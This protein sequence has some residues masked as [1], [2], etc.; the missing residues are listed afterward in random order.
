ML[1]RENPELLSVKDSLVENQNQLEKTMATVDSQLDKALQNLK[2]TKAIFNDLNQEYAGRIEEVIS[3]V[4]TILENM[5]VSKSEI[6]AVEKIFDGT[7]SD[8]NNKLDEVS[9]QLDDL[10]A[11]KIPPPPVE[12]LVKA[13]TTQI[14]RRV[15]DVIKADT[16]LPI[17]RASRF[18][19]IASSNQENNFGMLNESTT[20][21]VDEDEVI[22]RL[23][24]QL[25][26]SKLVQTELSAD[27]IELK[28]DLRKAYKEIVS[29]QTN[30]KESRLIIEELETAKNSLYKTVD[31][32][33]ATAAA[34]SKRVKKLEADLDQARDD[35]RQSRQS[36]LLEQ[37]RSNS[38]ISSIT[39]EL[40]RTRKELDYARV[41]ARQNAGSAQ[42]LAFFR[43]RI[44]KS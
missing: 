16:A 7:I 24:S 33:P 6:L 19:G 26:S 13:P 34:V 18:S 40:E 39:S 43:K 14:G 11:K 20:G 22:D 44:S 23:R 37:Q 36:L 35:L 25:E 38:M 4:L 42:R 9:L 31:G 15:A 5:R 30:L 29:L 41:S 10:L 8:Y 32:G 12:K 2:S 1:D 27:S 17:G 28:S 3:P 21:N